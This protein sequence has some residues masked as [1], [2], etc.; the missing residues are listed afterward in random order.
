V[1]EAQMRN[2]SDPDFVEAL[3]RGLAIITAFSPTATELSVSDV[4]ARTELPRPTARRLLM[5]L[6]KLGYVRSSNGLYR[7]TTKV[8]ELGTTYI[9]ALGIWEL[10]RPHLEALVAQ[11]GESSSMAQLD[12]SDIVYVARVPVPKIIALA[13]RIGTRFPAVATS[14]GYVLLAGL[15]LSEALRVVRMPS[16]SGVIPRI[17]PSER[18]LER[19]LA[20]VRSRGWALSDERLSLGIRSIAAPVRD[21]SGATV[22]AVNVTVHA[23]ETSIDELTSRHLP[24]LLATAEDITRE[25]ANLALLPVPDPLASG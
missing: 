9:A 10:A 4:A 22:A 19:E 8:L 24:L 17:T 3:A 20:E 14:M 12:G 11:T 18:D 2:G 1:E 25:W 13:V 7:L 21:A 5:T 23:A 16:Q 6:E 15:P